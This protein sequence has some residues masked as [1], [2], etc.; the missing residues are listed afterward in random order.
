MMFPAPRTTRPQL[1]AVYLLTNLRLTGLQ[2]KI[3]VRAAPHIMVM[4]HQFSWM[5]W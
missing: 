2:I 4:D 5:I 1:H 3:R